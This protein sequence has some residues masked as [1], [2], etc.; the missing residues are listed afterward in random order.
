MINKYQQQ[1]VTSSLSR[2]LIRS[3]A[4]SLTLS[5]FLFLFSG[6][7]YAQNYE[8]DWA[9]SGGGMQGADQIYDV[10]VGTDNNYYFI[11]SLYGTI[12]TQLD[13]EPVN[14]NN[15]SL[16]GDDIFLFS[17]DCEGQVRWSQ[18]I[19][20]QG[21]MD[22]AY[23]LALD[24][25]NNVF[26]GIHV[27]GGVNYSI[28]FDSDPNNSIPPLPDP[29]AYKR[30]YLVKYDSNGNFQAKKALQGSVDNTN[31]QAQL[32]DLFIDSN[33]TIHFITGL[34]PGTHLDNN[35]TVP[36]TIMGWQYFLAKY[37]TDLNYVSSISLPIDDGTGFS[38]YPIRFVYDINLDV[39][40]ISGI[41]DDNSSL[42][43]LTYDS[44]TVQNRSFIIAFNGT[45]GSLEWLREL[46]SNNLNANT[47]AT[48]RIKS[49]RVDEN[50]DVYVGGEI[51]TAENETNI[52]IYDPSD[53][54]VQPYLFAPGADWTIPM[55]IKFDSS[56]T[57]Q[58]VQA[59]EA[60]NANA[61]TPGPRRGGGIAI[62]G[63]EVV[64]ATQGANEF[65][66]NIEIQRPVS[67]QP[68][69]LL[70]RFDKQTGN[71]I[72][73]HDIQGSLPDN[74]N[75]VVVAADNDGNYITGGT[76]NGG[77]FTNN[78]S[79]VAPISSVGEEDFF[80]AKLAA[81]MCGTPVSTEEFNTI[82]I[83]VFPNPTTDIVYFETDEKLT[84]YS[85]FNQNA[86]QVKVHTQIN[87]TNYQMSL[88]GLASG[89]YFILLKT[90][91]GKSTTVK[92]VKE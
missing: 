44:K 71:V 69:P 34:R 29:E 22:R 73:L 66:G 45:D 24:S 9:V 57:V 74:Q 2:N 19:G 81:S 17:T 63:G 31:N 76:F 59:T 5:C 92:V 55:I 3:L 51:Y 85:V 10:K 42:I 83:N 26:A 62:R 64:L 90:E 50:S 8:W 52:K 46:Y 80:V 6:L 77:L 47:L 41:R 60:Y 32:L 37:D 61:L 79:N 56:G 58:W 43:P 13:G 89:T 11:G 28:G 48:N 78:N 36:N 72:A 91:S 84:T 39:Y 21:G 88:D 82:A 53:T 25:N 7:S 18:S 20:G 67:H 86:Q 87:E 49:L 68:D 33:D 75:M 16:G 65:W 12:G 15:S 35:V 1:P 27:Q 14:T 23:N 40:Y 4:H 30:I 70:V 54:S 38:N